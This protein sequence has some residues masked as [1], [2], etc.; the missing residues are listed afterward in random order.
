MFNNASNQKEAISRTVSGWHVWILLRIPAT[1]ILWDSLTASS[2]TFG[3]IFDRKVQG[4]TWIFQPFCYEVWKQNDAILGGKLAAVLE[5]FKHG[6]HP[7][8]SII[9]NSQWQTQTPSKS[10]KKN[11]FEAKGRL[12]T[13]GKLIQGLF[14]IDL[15]T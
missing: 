15:Y 4:Q 14:I 12:Y 2:V 13:T 10:L 8:P 1:R 9:R 6:F 7:C 11:A 3:W 5:P